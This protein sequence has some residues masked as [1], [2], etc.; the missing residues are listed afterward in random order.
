[1]S[2]HKIDSVYCISPLSAHEEL[3]P[4]LL[5]L[6]DN[7]PA[8]GALSPH[9]SPFGLVSKDNHFYSKPAIY[10]GNNFYKLDWNKAGDFNREWVTLIL[11]FLIK[12]VSTSIEE[13]GYT[14]FSFM[15]IWFQ[16]YESA[17]YQDWH[18]HGHN[19][20]GVY[21]VDLPDN[22]PKTVLL[23]PY[24]LNS[25]ITPEVGEGDVLLFSSNII[26]KS[27]FI[28]SKIRKTIVSFNIGLRYVNKHLIT[29]LYDIYP[30]I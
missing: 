1:M 14:D 21:Y 9:N 18:V 2:L 13:M 29:K 23:N 8:E 25:L 28:E 24:D 16:Q 19:L 27:P 10:K 11:P 7:L 12:N 3:K 15:E 6:F 5:D 26:H 17:G 20:T 4:K 30:N 22:A